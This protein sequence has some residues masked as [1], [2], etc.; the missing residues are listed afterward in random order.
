[1]QCSK[2][3]KME[4]NKPPYNVK[5]HTFKTMYQLLKSGLNKLRTSLGGGCEMT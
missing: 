4:Q 1:M 2:T 5:A 3:N